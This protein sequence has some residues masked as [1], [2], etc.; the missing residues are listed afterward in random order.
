MLKAKQDWKLVKKN[1]LNQSEVAEHKPSL[2]FQACSSSLSNFAHKR[3]R[4]YFHKKMP[5]I[6]AKIFAHSSCNEIQKQSLI[7]HSFRRQAGKARTMKC[8]M[9]V[10]GNAINSSQPLCVHCCTYFRRKSINLDAPSP[11]SRVGKS[12]PQV[13]FQLITPS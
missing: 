7:N 11:S 8:S 9:M 5:S 1:T 2:P 3:S 4:P 12:L 6:G 13:E 10:F